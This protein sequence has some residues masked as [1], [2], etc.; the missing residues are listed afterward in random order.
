MWRCSPPAPEKVIIAPR[1][2]RA[3][4][5]WVR[6]TGTSTSGFRSTEGA[7]PDGTS[8]SRA[9]ARCPRTGPLVRHTDPREGDPAHRVGAVRPA[10]HGLLGTVFGTLSDAGGPR[11]GTG[12]RREETIH[13]HL[14]A[15][16]AD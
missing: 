15:H 10:G 4:H 6:Q 16:S 5:R 11:T 9:T 8:G 1:F 13:P 3:R 12:A 2:D 14:S 7:W